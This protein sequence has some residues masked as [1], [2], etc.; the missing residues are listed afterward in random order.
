MA[1]GGLV[2]TDLGDGGGDPNVHVLVREVDA[3]ALERR[4]LSLPVHR[5]QTLGLVPF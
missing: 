3:G 2:A 5:E 4:E 1:M